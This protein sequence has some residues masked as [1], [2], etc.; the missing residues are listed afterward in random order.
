[1]FLIPRLSNIYYLLIFIK[2]CCPGEYAV[3][4]MFL[5]IVNHF[6]CRIFF[7][8]LARTAN[9]LFCLFLALDLLVT[10]TKWQSTETSDYIL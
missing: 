3:D 4:V 1:M 7:L 2:K 6:A 8:Q 10:K 9:C 5:D